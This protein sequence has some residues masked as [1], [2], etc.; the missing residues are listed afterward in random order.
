MFEL[1]VSE[2]PLLAL[3][4][5]QLL[6]VVPN[7]SAIVSRVWSSFTLVAA[8][9]TA[10]N[11]VSAQE[12]DAPVRAA[13]AELFPSNAPSMESSRLT[14]CSKFKISVVCSVTEFVRFERFDVFC[15]TTVTR[16][17]VLLSNVVLASR[18]VRRPLTSALFD[19]R[20]AVIATVFAW[21]FDIN[22]E[23]ESTSE[24]RSETSDALV[25]C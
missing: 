12:T 13:I 16:A 9:S 19:A 3:I 2:Y 18:S 23:S 5:S 10:L 24:R 14:D 6:L 7:T 1:F 11:N 22:V 17:V 4:L 20:S 21:R 8:L 15:S 25:R